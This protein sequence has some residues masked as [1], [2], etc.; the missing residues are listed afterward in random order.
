MDGVRGDEVLGE[1]ENKQ[2]R[3]TEKERK[4]RMKME[5]WWKM[6]ICEWTIMSCMPCVCEG[7]GTIVLHPEESV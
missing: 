2:W 3:E 6:E 4:N 5:E 7:D 1:E